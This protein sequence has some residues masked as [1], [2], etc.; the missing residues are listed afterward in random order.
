MECNPTIYREK[1]DKVIQVEGEIYWEPVDT[2]ISFLYNPDGRLEP[3]RYNVDF[4]P[5]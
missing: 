3:K 2:I 5:Q 4:A 1:I